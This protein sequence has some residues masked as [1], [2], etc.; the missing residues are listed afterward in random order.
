MGSGAANEPVELFDEQGGSR[1]FYSPL[2]RLN[3]LT[4][5]EWLYWT[6]SVIHRPY[7]PNCQHALRRLH[8]GQK[9]PDLCADLIRVFTKSDALVLDPFMGVGGTLLGAARAGRRAVGIEINPRWIEIYREVCRREGLARFPAH[10]GDAA[11]VLEEISGPFDLVLT[12]VPYWNMDVAPRS[13]GSYKRVG[14]PARPAAQTRLDRFG[15]ASEYADKAAWLGAMQR[16]FRLACERLK[17][18]GHLLSFIGDM[19]MAGSYHALSAELGAMLSGIEPLVW[20]AN[21]VWY[22]VSKK[23]HIYGYRYRYIPSLVHQNV[24]VFRKAT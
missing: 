16:V 1:G 2:N 3:E 6:R 19:Y 21:L 15:A 13:Q 8:G 22:D 18:G 14:S 12:D 4:G 9:P 24:L 23:L 11:T 20:Q 10:A 5:K 7:P 17:P